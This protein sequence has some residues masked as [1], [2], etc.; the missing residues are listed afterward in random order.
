MEA[1]FVQIGCKCVDTRR[2]IRKHV[3]LGYKDDLSE[4]VSNQGYTPGSGESIMHMQDIEERIKK[5]NPL[6]ISHKHSNL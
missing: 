4:F 3:R 5:A 1:D 2:A 6:Q